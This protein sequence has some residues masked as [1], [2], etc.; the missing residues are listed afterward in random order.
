[1]RPRSPIFF[2]SW[3][4]GTTIVVLSS[5]IIDVTT[6]RVISLPSLFL[7]VDCQ[8]VTATTL[9]INEINSPELTND[10]MP[11]SRWKVQW[12]LIKYQKT[13]I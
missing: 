10:D 6:S 13:D 9:S 11:Q 4:L 12:S 2:Y 3:M 1:M 7:G 5:T 8:H